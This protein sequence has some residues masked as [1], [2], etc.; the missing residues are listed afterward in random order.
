MQSD[1][2]PLPRAAAET[3][4]LQALSWIV[5]DQDVAARFMGQTGIGPAELRASVSD[6]EFLGFVLDFILAD[7]PALLAF[8]EARSI[9]PERP[10]RARAGLP[11]GDLPHWT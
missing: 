9:A 8:C 11:G 3:L 2:T 4:A 6:P 7:E 10:L 5:A 1:L